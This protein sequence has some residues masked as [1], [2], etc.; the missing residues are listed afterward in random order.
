MLADVGIEDV[1]ALCQEARPS[2]QC[3]RHGN[4]I[5]SRCMFPGHSDA[6]PSMDI[7]FTEGRV[8]A[9]CFS[10]GQYESDGFR[11]VEHITGIHA[12]SRL[13]A[14]IFG[15]RFGL[16]VDAELD[17]A[18]VQEDLFSHFKNSVLRAGEH[19]LVNASSTKSKEYTYAQS[20]ITYL[21]Q[22]G[23]PATTFLTL[24]IGIFPTLE[25]FAQ[26]A[27]QDAQITIGEY[28]GP[29]V[30]EQKPKAVGRYG[31]WLMFP[32]YTSPTT[33]GRLKLRDPKNK[34]NEVWLGIHKEETR[35]FFGLNQF[36]TL[37]GK[38]LKEAKTAYVVEGEFDQLAMLQAQLN[39]NPNQ[40]HIVLGGSGSA[41]TSLDILADSRISRVT[42]VGDN[43]AG[44]DQFVRRILEVSEQERI[45]DFGVYDWSTLQ[46]YGDP[47]D[48]VQGG[49]Y[50]DL[51][52]GLT[53]RSDVKELH[54]WAM[55]TALKEIA[56]LSSPSSVEKID[57]LDK[58][59]AF[60]KNDVERGLY[61]SEVSATTGL[62]GGVLSK[63]M[64]SI[65]TERGFLVALERK[66]GEHA[67][68]VAMKNSETA[69]MFCRNS[70]E[71]FEVNLRKPRD[72][73]LAL[74]MQVFGCTTYDF[75]EEN[76]GIPDRVRYT[77]GKVPTER[78]INHQAKDLSGHVDLA[79][80]N[81]VA[82]SKPLSKYRVRRQ[83]VHWSDVTE[84]PVR[85]EGLP[86]S[87]PARCVYVVNGHLRLMGTPGSNGLMY[88]E[89]LSEPVHGLNLLWGDDEPW[90]AMLTSADSANKKPKHT[91]KEVYE[92]LLD[93]VDG[94]A[95]ERHDLVRHFWAAYIMM[96]THCDIFE[97][98]P[99]VLLNAPSQSGKSTML[100][101]VLRGEDPGE[102]GLIEHSRGYDDYTAAAVMQHAEGSPILMGLEE[103]EAAD[104]ASRNDSKARAVR[105]ILASVRN[106]S[107]RKGMQRSRG[108]RY[109]N[110]SDT[111]LRFPISGAAIQ[112]LQEEADRN[113][114]FTFELTQ[115]P[116]KL[117]PEAYIRQKLGW[118]GVSDLRESI[119]LNSLQHAHR[120]Y[121]SEQDI[122][123]NVWDKDVLTTRSTRGAKSVA[124]ILTI[125]KDVEVD[126][127]SWGQTF[128]DWRS[129]LLRASNTSAERTMFLAVFETNAITIPNEFQRRSLI[130]I[131]ANPDLRNHLSYADCG[132]YYLPGATFVVLYPKKIAEILKYNANY[133]HSTNA[134]Q[135]FNHLKRNPEVKY[136]PPFFNKSKKTMQHLRQFM[137]SVR[138]EDL[139][140]VSFQAL[141]FDKAPLL[142]PDPDTVL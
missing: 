96:L 134:N 91:R 70:N 38:D 100:K 80:Q 34:D 29:R 128:L 85:A 23:F 119:L 99:Y 39:L 112:P 14:E 40:Q 26:H 49:D 15:Q 51:I 43:D 8:F 84:D 130:N 101:G 78:P 142:T 21:A 81:F 140:A 52:H 138:A 3:E 66:L 111:H 28:F 77:Q 75:V 95:F 83:G 33:I 114:W 90:S 36:T 42:L 37:V 57:V 74:Q 10:C 94:W 41:P 59:C 92:L 116:G 68:P 56:T 1:L 48:V 120:D 20:A 7:V 5:R 67:S 71:I 106:A 109:G 53:T 27:D 82:G 45:H 131:L 121:L 103:F 6:N 65:D 107:G 16:K 123:Q 69:L 50:P 98:L 127:L 122:L 125:M 54:M 64:V 86:S 17:D 12:I 18:L 141:D 25:H 126:Y 133:R 2:H 93:V 60:I 97:N 108:G 72:I 115:Q 32:Y 47:D 135:I 105:A 22:R 62:D 9:K 58:G 79:V 89:E 19:L 137:P 88:Y 63:H 4:R 44:G 73:E 117:P 102:I 24:G 55:D 87:A 31:G 118:D 104:D 113:R 110:P 124:P 35:G 139:L 76:I 136:D 11:I 13:Y 129:D 46:T 30:F 132:A 61:V